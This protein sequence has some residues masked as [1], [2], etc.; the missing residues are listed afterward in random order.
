[1]ALLSVAKNGRERERLATVLPRLLRRTL[2][3]EQFSQHTV[4]PSSGTGIMQATQNRECLTIGDEGSSEVPLRE[5]GQPFHPEGVRL[6][7]PITVH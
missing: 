2:V 7:A 1:M 5:A 4:D 3:V 6:E